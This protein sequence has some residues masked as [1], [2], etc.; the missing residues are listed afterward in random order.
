MGAATGRAGAAIP[1]S[2]AE[3][4][5]TVGSEII[6]TPCADTIRAPRNIT[7]VRGE[8]GDDVIYGQRGNDA[9]YGGEGNDRLYGGVGDDFLRGGPGD[10]RLY[11]GFGADSLDGEAGNDFDSGDATVDQ[12]GDSGGGTD[13]LSFATGATP[14][15]P[16][17]SSFFNEAGFPPDVGRGVYV[18]LGGSFAN[19][20]LAPSGGGVDEP[21]AP[22]TNFENFEVVIGT[23]FDDYIVGT[24]HAET[25]YGGGGA[26]FIEGGGGADVAYG[27]A[28]GDACVA[29]TTHECESTSR[30]TPRGPTTTSAGLMAPQ[31]GGGPA[32]FFSGTGGDDEVVATYGSGQVSFTLGGSPA[33]SFPVSEAPNSIVLAGLAGNDTLTATDFPESTSVVLLGGEGNDH[34][35]SGATEDADIDGAGDDVVKAGAGDD[36]VPNNGG[37]DIL[38]AGEGDDLFIDNAVCD[39]DQLDGGPG[40][41]NANWANFGT[42]VSLDLATQS[43]GLVG[44]GGVPSCP[45]GTLTSL[46]GLEDLEGTSLADTLVGDAGENQLLGRPGADTYHAGAGNDSILANSGTPGTDPDAV[47]DCGIGFDTAQIDRPTNGPDPAPSECEVSEEREP[48][49]FRPPDTPPATPDTSIATGPPALTRST[50]AEFSFSASPAAGA[51]FECE[52]DGEAFA[53]CASPKT[54]S[55]LSGTG[56]AT[57]TAHTFGVR[58]VNAGGADPTPASYTWTVDTVKPTATITG[59]PPDPSG[60]KSVAFAFQASESATFSCS[61]EGPKPSAAAACAS[62]VTYSNLTNG[63]YTFRVMATDAAGNVGEPAVYSWRVDNSIE[64]P[65]PPIPDTAIVS[66][67]PAVTN[68]T[69]AEFGFTATPAAGAAF[70]CRLDA[71]AFAACTAPQAYTGLAGDGAATGTQHT[72][73][74][75]AKNSSGTDPSPASYTWTVDTVRPRLSL[76]ERPPEPSTSHDAAFSFAADEPAT[77]TCSLTGPKTSVPSPCSSPVSYPGLPDGSYTFEVTAADLA[78]NPADPVSYRWQVASPT[79]PPVG[80]PTAP[81]EPSPSGPAASSPAT[82]PADT[83]YPQTRIAPDTA[84]RLR[85]GRDGRRRVVFRF[86]ANESGATF[87]CRLDRRRPTP[88]TA[89]RA[90]T[91]AIGAH[92]FRVTATDAAGDTDPSPALVRFRVRRSR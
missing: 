80:S 76:T 4:P 19:D 86:S 92:T 31:A 11:G 37:A 83:R 73:Q 24:S 50:T 28:E 49:S 84:N 90:Y 68:G 2:C 44:G 5:Q 57:G 6:G 62:G 16:N 10:D 1:P 91:V 52:L 18:E 35:T 29:P 12:I 66:R 13:T 79:A 39:G 20:G 65:P 85:A 71:A 67:P 32:L 75:R 59:P 81:A 9:L 14:G 43:G 54:Y 63:T 8:G 36:A 88:C 87:V 53:P 21:L 25:F 27:G 26:D 34:L 7:V 30:I 74:V 61:L 46:T 38:D 78:G 33:G 40:R 64:E 70:E 60:G 51:S 72:F 42:G 58:A 3:G 41:D 15:F 45:S 69:T 55:G 22:A 48:N 23:P 56:S 82:P 77:F 47:I 89:P 17:Q